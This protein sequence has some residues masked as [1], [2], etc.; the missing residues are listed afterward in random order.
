MHRK[1]GMSETEI[2][3]GYGITTTQLRAARSIAVAQ[4]R[5]TKI[6]TA[7]RLK[8]KGWS[9][10]AIGTRMGL[11][12]S[13]VRALLAPGEK[14]KADALQSTANML[15]EQVN[16]K[17]YVDIGGGVENQLGITQTRLS[18]AVAVLKEEGYEVHNIKVQQVGTGKF[19]TMKV[20][21]PPGTALSEVQKN[22]SEIKQ[23]NDTYSEDHGRSFL[24]T[25]PPI[26][27]SSKRIG[28]NYA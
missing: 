15:K 6:L 24:G 20:L 7:Q 5:Q 21:A 11:N 18:T 13:S 4:Q 17:K 19:T 10:V 12:E 23:I 9:N 1:D 16:K 8:E 27:V 22:R 26:S 3:R 28:I 14:D 25:Q 2:A